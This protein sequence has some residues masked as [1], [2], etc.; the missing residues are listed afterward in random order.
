MTNQLAIWLGILLL[1]GMML[2]YAMFGSEHFVFLGK[3]LYAF[4]M[5]PGI[6]SMIQINYFKASKT[7]FGR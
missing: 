6:L 7:P 5:S 3:K 4:F 2:D 1:G